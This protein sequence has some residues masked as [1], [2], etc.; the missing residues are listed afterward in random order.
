MGDPQVILFTNFDQIRNISETPHTTKVQV[1][2]K[3]NHINDFDVNMNRKTILFGV[4]GGNELIETST[5]TG[6][7]Q[8]M[9]G[10]PRANRIAHDWIT[11]NTYLVHYPDDMKVE[12][13]VCNMQTKGC[14]MIKKFESHK[15]IPS[16]QVDPI[17]RFLFFVEL[18]NP[19]YLPPTSIIMKTRLDGSDD[20]KVM[21]GTHITAISL[22]IDEQKVY[23][24]DMTLQSL[25]VID[26]SGE[27]R[28]TIV[29][30]TRFLKRPISMS[31]FDNHAYIL[32]RVTP[33]ITR[34]SLYGEKECRVIEITEN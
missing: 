5:E 19:I 25:Q 24:T 13:H 3:S 11:R 4:M 28:Q 10:V 8:V 16:I 7:H 9:E 1:D 33:G 12:I 23:S 6:E 32:N 26:Y 21:N 14:A 18:S 22:D 30:Q 29:K 31:L 15:Q 20:Q 27:N 17:N 34:C 2:M